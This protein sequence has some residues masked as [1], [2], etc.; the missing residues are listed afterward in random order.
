MIRS[1]RN[2]FSNAKPEYFTTILMITLS[3]LGTVV[4]FIVQTNILNS[5]INKD[6]TSCLIY[7]IIDILLMTLARLFDL[8]STI[9]QA[10]T[11]KRVNVMIK[12]NIG[13]KMTEM[14]DIEFS[15]SST[16]VYLSNL[17]NDC[18]LV[19][20]RVLANHFV[21]IYY[22]EMAILSFLAL[23][24][25]SI[26]IGI[27]S[28]FFFFIMYHFPKIFE[29]KTKRY[30]EYLSRSKEMYLHKIKDQIA[31]RDDYSDL[32]L[33]D[34][35]YSRLDEAAKDIEN[36][37]YIY[38]QKMSVIDLMISFVNMLAQFG[39][40]FI[41]AILAVFG[42]ISPGVVLSIG[43]LNGQFYSSLASISQT[44]MEMDSLSDLEDKLRYH[45][46]DETKKEKCPKIEEIYFNDIDFAYGET[47]V[48]KD[49]SV[50]F[51]APN[52]YLICGDN[53]TGKSTLLKLIM[54]KLKSSKGTY[55][56]NGVDAEKYDDRSIKEH[57]AYVT[58]MSHIFNMTVRDN[59]RLGE[60][61]DDERSRKVLDALGLDD[62]DLDMVIDDDGG[63]LSGGQRQKIVLA[64][65]ILRDRDIVISDESLSN[66][67]RSSKKKIYDLIAQNKKLVLVVDHA[68]E[69]DEEKDF[70]KISM[71]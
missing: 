53:G 27:F 12:N 3:V 59:L 22:I 30:T 20:D 46:V 15:R 28:I 14:D 33:L 23:L 69:K 38:T 9:F 37:K 34:S 19:E 29:N 8:L 57:I 5:I 40:F 67:D 68:L 70:I 56:I 43:N 58:H 64:R 4:A 61:I 60:K 16:N 1:Y 50:R 31:G 11:I 63:N 47:E 42:Y 45:K 10:K 36:N 52:R 71:R 49:K 13:R 25:Y 65:A 7:I 21:L 66:I 55:L 39:S 44:I 24:L 18:D 62:I 41:S 48:I 51:V 32:C 2:Y 26:Y 35:F 54:R 6:L 17:T